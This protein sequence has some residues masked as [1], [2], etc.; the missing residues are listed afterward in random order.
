MARHALSDEQWECIAPYFPKPKRMGR[1]RADLRRVMDGILWIVRSGSPWRDLPE[2]EF[3]P[4][5]TVYCHFNTWSKNGTLAKVLRA[6]KRVLS[7][8]Q[9]FDHQLW[10]LDGTLVRAARCA[11]GGGKKGGLGSRKTMPWAVLAEDSRPRSTW[12]AMATGTL[13]TST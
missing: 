10:C 4:W 12:S 5:E 3:G 2:A 11:G 13:C 6:L 7:D 8:T 1:P 9:D